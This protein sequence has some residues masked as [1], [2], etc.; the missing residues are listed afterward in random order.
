MSVSP[1]FNPVPAFELSKARYFPEKAK[2][3]YK[4]MSDRER[5]TV[6]LITAY[7]KE[8]LRARILSDK[9]E[10]LLPP[11][12]S[13]DN[14]TSAEKDLALTSDVKKYFEYLGYTVTLLPTKAF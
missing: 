2:L 10:K 12:L 11:S 14:N 7:L 8:R 4:I 13:I 3:Y 9:V 5:Q 6:D 1:E